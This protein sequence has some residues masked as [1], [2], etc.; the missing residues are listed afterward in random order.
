MQKGS[1]EVWKCG[2]GE[3]K[4]LDWQFG[5]LGPTLTLTDAFP[6][7]VLA[8]RKFRLRGPG[9]GG[10]VWVAGCDVLTTTLSCERPD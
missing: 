1:G 2:S 6:L 7:F 10:G 8:S 4:S 3:E 5:G 9:P